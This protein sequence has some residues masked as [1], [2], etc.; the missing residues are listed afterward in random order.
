VKSESKAIRLQAPTALLVLAAFLAPLL[1]GQLPLEAGTLQGGLAGAILSIFGGGDV[2][3]LSHLVVATLV[4]VAFILVMLGRRVVQVPNNTLGAGLLVFFGLLAFSPLLSGFKVVSIATAVE[5]LTYGFAFYAVVG[6]VGR[7]VGPRALLGAIFAGCVVLAALGL[8]EYG[9]NK[10]IDPTWRI[11]PWWNNPNALAVMLL[12]GFFLGGGL[13][14][15]SD[16]PLSLICG[17]GTV[18]VGLAIVLTQSKGALLVLMAGTPVLAI[19]HLFGAQPKHRPRT[20]GVW[21]AIALT[22]V[23]A[24]F[25][26]L[27][28]QRPAATTGGTA[29]PLGRVANAGS[30][31]EQSSGFRRLLWRTSLELVKENPAGYGLGTFRYVSARPGLN[32]QTVYAHNAYLQLAVEGSFVL[33]VLLILAV[34]FWLWLALKGI[35][36]VP[37]PNRILQASVIVAVGAVLTHSLIDSD[38]Y[39]YGVG[40]SV[41]MLLG[42][43]LLLSADSVA[44]EF[45]FPALRRMGAA[46]AVVVLG[47]FAYFAYTEMLRSEARGALARRDA[48]AALAA[49]ET[50]HSVAPVDGEA[51]YLTA[52]VSP[53]LDKQIEAAKNAVENAPSTRNLRLLA[54]LLLDNGDVAGATLMYNRALRSDPNSL[55][56]LSQLAELYRKSGNE[57]A[58]RSTLDR[59]LKVEDTTYFKIRSLPELVPTETY[60]ARLQLA[61]LTN[62]QAEKRRLL[63]GAVAGFKAYLSS[64]VPTVLRMAKGDPP[65]PYGGETVQIATEKMQRAAEAAHRL[66]VLDLAAGDKAGAEEAGKAEAAFLGGIK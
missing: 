20:F 36:T 66:G 45:L 9:Q 40:M 54:R 16:R 55:T 62:D 38:L 2:A 27:F 11:F 31:G 12:V 35:S 53:T 43:G 5:W 46:L 23:V 3:M 6:T 49:V 44:P 1:G 51:W 61:E 13:T 39:Y 32:T 64:T 42:V 48:P 14:V 29:S 22:L 7:R 8:R 25:G 26:L 10:V 57:S 63:T 24:V 52:Q 34:C 4:L 50:L 60:E 58:Y 33:P 37:P 65:L 18:L 19:A 47:S 17:L 15:I 41:F 56:T 21:A 30:T 59:L 28:S